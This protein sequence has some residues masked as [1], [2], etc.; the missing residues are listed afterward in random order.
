MS[1]LTTFSSIHLLASS[2]NFFPSS[3]VGS[4]RWFGVRLNQGWK[5]RVMA[6]HSGSNWSRGGESD[7]E[8]GSSRNWFE[9]G[10]L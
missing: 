1:L 7:S 10:S 9:K 5:A 3:V 2:I 4:G 6:S 8:V